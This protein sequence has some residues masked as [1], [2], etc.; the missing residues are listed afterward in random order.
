[1]VELKAVAPTVTEEKL[2]DLPVNDDGKA[3]KA[4]EIYWSLTEMALVKGD[5]VTH[6]CTYLFSIKFTLQYG[7]H[8]HAALAAALPAPPFPGFW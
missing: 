2:L 5:V 4:L 1:M 3:Q 7:Q 6:I 8:E